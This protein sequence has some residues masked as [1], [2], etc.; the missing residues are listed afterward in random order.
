MPV[1]GMQPVVYGELRVF[2]EIEFPAALSDEQRDLLRK[3]L[4]R[5]AAA[6]AA[7]EPPL[8]LLDKVAWN[9]SSLQM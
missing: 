5:P 6:A 7:A 2:F 1:I 9:A 3:A 8:H 4:G